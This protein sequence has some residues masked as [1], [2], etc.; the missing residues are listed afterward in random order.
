MFFPIYNTVCDLQILICSSWLDSHRLR[1][2]ISHIMKIKIP[3]SFKAKLGAMLLLCLVGVASL[4]WW[5]GRHERRLLQ[6]R[7]EFWERILTKPTKSDVRVLLSCSPPDPAT[8]TRATVFDRDTGKGLPMFPGDVEKTR[9]WRAL[10]AISCK[11]EIFILCE[12]D[13]PA[14]TG[15]SSYRSFAD[16]HGRV[17]VTRSEVQRKNLPLPEATITL[18]LSKGQEI[19]RKTYQFE[20]DI[21]GIGPSFTIARYRGTGTLVVKHGNDILLTLGPISCEDA[22]LPEKMHFLKHVDRW[23]DF[24][25]CRIRQLLDKVDLPGLK[26]RYAPLDIVFPENQTMWGVKRHKDL[27]MRRMIAGLVHIGWTKDILE[28]RRLAR[29]DDWRETALEFGLPAD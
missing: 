11:D 24:A 19:E 10:E 28:A 7:D 21:G 23:E 13:D 8:D 12:D 9:Y 3:F 2:Y 18:T 17:L 4:L 29:K 22:S 15:S 25:C 5:C 1:P 6:Y 27:E 14:A 20:N 16:R 26:N